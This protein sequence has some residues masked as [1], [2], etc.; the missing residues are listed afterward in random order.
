MRGYNSICIESL[1]N[2]SRDSAAPQLC[3][4]QKLIFF[5]VCS[6]RNFGFYRLKFSITSP[7]TSSSSWVVLGGSCCPDGGGRRSDPQWNR[8]ASPQVA[9]NQSGGLGERHR[10][11]LRTITG[12]NRGRIVSAVEFFHHRLL[13]SPPSSSVS[14]VFLAGKQGR[15]DQL[16]ASIIRPLFIF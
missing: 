3:F 2:E 4:M 5:N 11:M 15:T 13:F 7:Y 1:T 6:F 12:I 14:S 8:A 9:A 16:P 10:R